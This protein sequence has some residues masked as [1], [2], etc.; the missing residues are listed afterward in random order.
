MSFAERLK[1]ARLNKG[2]TQK[3]LAEKIGVTTTAITNYETGVRSPK[4]SVMLKIF[5][6]L[7]VSPNE[8]FKDNFS[9]EPTFT[10]YNPAYKAPVYER[11]SAGLPLLANDS[12]VGYE[13]IDRKDDA[14]Y[15]V[16]RVSGDS[17]NAARIND[18]DEIVVRRQS[19]VD[20]GDIA[21]V[22]VNGYDATVKR[23]KRA[24]NTVMLIPQSTN[25]EHT[26]QVYDKR[27]D[28]RILG[29]V[30]SVKFDL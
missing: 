15:F 27:T 6:A 17:M 11:I 13:M 29:K 19:D 22:L 14:E 28:I 21:V 4:E 30:V 10:P 18:G 9:S 2:L 20:D 5:D 3:E 1:S 7:S 16:L 26:V 24:G 25:P 12:I 8:L 23:I